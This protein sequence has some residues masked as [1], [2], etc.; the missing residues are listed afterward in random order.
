LGLIL[1][2]FDLHKAIIILFLYMTF[3]RKTR[4][5]RREEVLL[6]CNIKNKSNGLK[7]ITF[8]GLKLFIEMMFQLGGSG[9]IK[10]KSKKNLKNILKSSICLNHASFDKIGIK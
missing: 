10:G 7:K 2:C 1:C 5:D 6:G 3:E 9:K 4:P 8:M